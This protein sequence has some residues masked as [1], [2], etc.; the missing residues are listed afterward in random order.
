MINRRKRGFGTYEVL[1]VFVLLLIIVVV[2]LANVFKTD[3][4]EKYDVMANNARMFALTVNN[5]YLEDGVEDVYYLQ[6]IMDKR[7]LSNVKN[8]FKGGKYCNPYTSKVDIINHKKYVTLE[9]GNYL[10]Y[11]QDSL[12]ASYAIYQVGS[13][14]SKKPSG[15]VQEEI[16]YNYQKNGKDVFSENLEE[17]IFLYEFNKIN[18]TNYQKVAEIKKDYSV[19]KDKRYRYMKKVN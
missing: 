15:T 18:G 5:L 17:D 3:Y 12:D 1:T 6:M 13:W 19:S 10:I 11:Q 7:L 8:P 2:L 14:S 4:K 16:V 9:C